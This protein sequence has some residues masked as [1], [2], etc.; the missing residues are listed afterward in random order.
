M[1]RRKLYHFVGK[2]AFDIEGCGP[3]TIDLLMD[4]GLVST[5]AD[6]FTLTEGDLEGLPGFAALAAKNLIDGITARKKITLDRLLIGLSID[7]VGEE[8]ARDIAAHF[9]NLY[10]VSKAKAERLMDVEGVGQVVADSMHVWFQNKEHQKSLDALLTHITVQS[11]GPKV[12]G[13]LTGKSFV[14]TGTLTSMSREEAEAR[15]RAKGGS[16]SSAVSAKTSYVVVGDSPGSKADKA[17]ELG[18]TV[19]NEKEFLALL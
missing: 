12:A 6:L 11:A 5:Y 19:L 4:E 16:I 9:G 17:R 1:L 15:V 18:V 10:R 13:T 7:H 8:T 2:H 14:I 3:K